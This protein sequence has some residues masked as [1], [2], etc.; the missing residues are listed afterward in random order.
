M[1][2]NEP[3][4]L[5]CGV[6]IKNRI[7]KSAMSET[8][9]T[10]NNRATPALTALYRRWAAGGVGLNITGNVMVD[11]RYLGEPQN[12][13]VEDR[14]QME[15]LRAWAREG[16]RFGTELWMQLNHPGKQ[17]PIILSPKTVAPSAIGFSNPQLKRF[18]AMPR[19][20][21]DDEIRDIIARFA[22][23]AE[24]AKDAGFTGVQIHGAHGYLVNQFLSPLH[25]Q[26]DDQWGGSLENR[27]RFV[28]EIYLAIR[29]A[30][31]PEFPVGIKLNSADFQRG[32]FTEEES[33]QVV[34]RLA[35]LGMDLIEISG[36]TYEQPNMA[37]KDQKESTRSREAYFIEYAEK[38]RQRVS[39]PL[40]VTGGFRTRAGMEAALASGATDLVG[41]ARPLV[42]DPDFPNLVLSGSDQASPVKPIRTGIKPVDDMAMMEVSWYTLQLARL[43]RGKAA[44]KDASGLV[45]LLKV[46]GVVSWRRLRMGRL[47]AA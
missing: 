5:P 35:E 13:A 14:T 41:L 45:S 29:A 11:R 30:V 40:M 31:G 24:I 42:L 32:G 16:T 47:R 27:M 18:F 12:V 21:T 17:S 44:A 19:A 4:T 15:A 28:C 3:L 7:G 43:A 36:G 38:V 22:R 9:G 46:V 25:N 26:R 33:M 23:T 37:G 39:V 2:I 10:R 6:T 34:E 1:L 8:L 20:L